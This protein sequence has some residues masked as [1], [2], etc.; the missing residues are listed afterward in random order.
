M[1]HRKCRVRCRLIVSA[2]SA[3]LLTPVLGA[4]ETAGTPMAGMDHGA[5]RAQDSASPAV[6]ESK[7]EPAP[8]FSDNDVRRTVVSYAV[9]SLK[10]MRDD[11]TSVWLDKELN[12]G[13]PVVLNFVYTSCTTICPMSSQEF[14]RLQQRL[15][16]DRDNVHLVSISIDPEQDTPSR[17]RD[18]ARQFHAGKAWQYYTGTA[19]S[20]VKAQQAFDA[21]RG[22]KMSHNPVTLVRAAPGSNWVRFDGF[23]GADDLYAELHT[24]LQVLRAAR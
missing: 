24:Q 23:V 19:A 8:M 22:G 10:M 7:A 13:R 20:S 1:S 21:Y 18:Y 9:P 17:L 2:V 15:G 5:M 12:D 3:C 16:S 14:A 6:A 4:H 11:G